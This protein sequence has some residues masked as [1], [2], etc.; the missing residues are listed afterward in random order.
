MNRDHEGRD[1]WHA[2]DDP[3][4]SRRG[5]REATRQMRNWVGELDY[6]ELESIEDSDELD[7]IPTF[8]RLRSRR[9]QRQDF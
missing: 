9:K 4:A 2:D 8:E 1:D 7:T 3:F 5:R 6:E